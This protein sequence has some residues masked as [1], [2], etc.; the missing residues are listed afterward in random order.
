MTFDFFSLL[1]AN[2]SVQT[3]KN[4]G[5]TLPHQHKHILDTL[6]AFKQNHFQFSYLPEVMAVW[7]KICYK[8]IS[9]LTSGFSKTNN[10]FN[11]GFTSF[12]VLCY[13]AEIIIVSGLGWPDPILLHC[14][15][16][17]KKKKQ[18]KD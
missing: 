18:D 4:V 11:Q 16:H 17:K 8:S 3:K 12:V 6:K 5:R 13:H 9:A 7:R 2:K 15:H 14:T 1:V 10:A